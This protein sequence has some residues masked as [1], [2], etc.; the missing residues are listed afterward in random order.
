[1]VNRAFGKLGR[2]SFLS[3]ESNRYCYSDLDAQEVFSRGQNPQHWYLS[4]SGLGT[5]KAGNH[6]EGE[7]FMEIARKESTLTDAD[8]ALAGVVRR[9]GEM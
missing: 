5:D 6:I 2:H 7:A 8:N 3:N 1:M 4:R 9:F